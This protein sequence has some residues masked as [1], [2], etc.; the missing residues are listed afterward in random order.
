MNWKGIA[1]IIIFSLIFLDSFFFNIPFGPLRVTLLRVGIF[2]LFLVMLYKILIKKE[3]LQLRSITFPLL[4]LGAWFF[5]GIISLIWTTNIVASIKELYYFAV[6]IVLIITLIYLLQNISST[7]II[8]TVWIGGFII[9]AI[10]FVE[11]LFDA[12][13]PTSR[14]VIEADRFSDLS[15][16]RATTF[17][18]NENDLAVFL[19]LILPFYLIGILNKS[20]IVKFLNIIMIVSLTLINYINDA[21]LGI[22]TIILQ[23]A[24]FVYFV[25]RNWI[26]KAIRLLILFSPT[27]LA[28][29]TI[30][31]L[32][33]GGFSA[34]FDKIDSGTGSGFIRLNLYLNSIYATYQ[35]FMLGVGPGNFQ[36]H[37]YPMFNTNGI[38]NPHNWW[39]EILTNYGLFVFTGYCSF[40][41]YIVKSLYLIYQSNKENNYLGLA[42]LVSF[43]GFIPASLAP[44]SLFYYWP[45]WL[46][47]G[48]TLAYISQ[49]KKN[50][51]HHYSHN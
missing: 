34:L 13:L 20:Y 17:F 14:Y 2:T 8:K 49:H 11:F 6:F 51:F 39:L 36:Y 43:S 38:I 35:S 4:F 5:Y 12:H 28:I 19:V 10:C 29:V 30:L 32:S 27:I 33:A 41:V 7:V 48:I 26:H 31:F 40:F 9:A 44:S 22:L 37:I 16:K 24:L 1:F 42:L 3:Q 18:Y 46:F 21:R 47:Y 15:L 45:M 23:I 25:K 50:I